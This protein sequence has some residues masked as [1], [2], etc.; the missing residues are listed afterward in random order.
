MIPSIKL[1][2]ITDD[3][4]I[5]NKS[6]ANIKFTYKVEHNGKISFLNVLLMRRN[7]KLETTVFPKETNNNDIYLHWRYFAPI[8]WKKVH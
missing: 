1:V 8:T 5:L 7:G 4:N 2:F 6:Q 3:I